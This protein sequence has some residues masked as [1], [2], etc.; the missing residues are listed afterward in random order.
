MAFPTTGNTYELKAVN[1]ILASVG[2]APVTSL[3]QTNPDVAICYDTLQEVSR[4]VQSE[5]W[6]FNREYYY[7]IQ[8]NSDKHVP[9]PN[10]MLRLDLSPGVVA[11]GSKDVI[12]RSLNG[13]SLLYDKV[14][15]TF[16]WD[17]DTVYCDVVWLFDWVDLPV[18]VQDYIT[19]RS[20]TI[21]GQRIVT[22]ETLVQ[23]L[24]IQE[25]QSRATL[26]EYECTQGD[27]SYF[28]HPPGSDYYQGYKPFEALY[29]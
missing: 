28:G 4:Q 22:E 20:A 26:M 29:R 8:V 19:K 5:G 6:A 3:D 24:T 21:V 11:Y 15:H 17:E 27:Y 2:Q 14:A 25:T 7:P 10:N 12:R 13:E 9:I 23:M 16:E 18:P 1:E